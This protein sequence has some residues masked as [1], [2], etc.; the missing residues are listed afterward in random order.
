[1]LDALPLHILLLPP[2]LAVGRVLTTTV[3]LAVAVQ[4]LLSVTVTV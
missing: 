4:P 3:V 1:M 2:M